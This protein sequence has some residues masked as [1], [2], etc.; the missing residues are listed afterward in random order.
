MNRIFE[1]SASGDVLQVVAGKEK[2]VGKVVCCD[3]EFID[4]ELADEDEE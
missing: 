1:L 2:K 4:F 3:G